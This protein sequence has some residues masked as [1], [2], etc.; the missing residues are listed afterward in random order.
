MSPLGRHSC[1]ALGASPGLIIVTH[2]LSPDEGRHSRT[3]NARAESAAPEGAQSTF[4]CVYPGFHF[5]L[6]PHYTLGFAGVPCLKAL[7][8][9]LNLPL[10]LQF[11]VAYCAH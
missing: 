1:I 9:R 8:I 4:I 11:I 2:L 5:G 6:C 7:V 10:C 3:I